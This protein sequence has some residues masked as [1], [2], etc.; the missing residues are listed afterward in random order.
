MWKRVQVALVQV[1]CGRRRAVPVRLHF[2]VHLQRARQDLREVVLD[3]RLGLQQLCG[4][5][6]SSAV[7]RVAVLLLDTATIG[8]RMCTSGTVSCCHLR[9]G[10]YLRVV[11]PQDLLQVA[12]DARQL[13]RVLRARV[14]RALS[15]LVH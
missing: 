5:S 7:A 6:V 9:D 11:R 15:V 3:I 14:C 2:V 13:V 1:A 4:R 8:S 12:L 10:S